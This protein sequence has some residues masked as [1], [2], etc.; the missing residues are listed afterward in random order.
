MARLFCLLLALFAILAETAPA[1]PAPFPRPVRKREKDPFD[2]F[3]RQ[4]K[5]R[6]GTSWQFGRHSSHHNPVLVY[7]VSVPKE[8]LII[9]GMIEVIDGNRVGAMHAA[10]AEIDSI[11]NPRPLE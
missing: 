4:F 6:G 11:R 2:E 10:L 1:A 8:G 9:R 5:A 3:D 7:E